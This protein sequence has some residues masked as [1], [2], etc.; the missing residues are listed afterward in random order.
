V[1]R[2]SL[3]L[4]GAHDFLSEDPL[5]TTE[6]N[7]RLKGDLATHAS[8]GLPRWQ[9]KVTDGGRIHYLVDEKKRTISFEAVTQGH[10]KKT[11]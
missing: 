10:P 9:Y 3:R 2:S 4:S 5:R 7:Y 8:T 1:Q 11:E 6:R